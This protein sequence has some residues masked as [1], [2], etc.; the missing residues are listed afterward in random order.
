MGF[1]CFTGNNYHRVGVIASGLKVGGSKG[2][3][4]ADLS[5]GVFIFTVL[6]VA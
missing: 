2:K 1:A 4:V 5:A 6:D 3:F